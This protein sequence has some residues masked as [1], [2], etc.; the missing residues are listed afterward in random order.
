MGRFCASA[1]ARD[2]LL[3]PLSRCP[4]TQGARRSGLLA[5]KVIDG[6]YFTSTPLLVDNQP[7]SIVKLPAH[8]LPL[9]VAPEVIA[10]G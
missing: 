2:E 8:S 4:A 5:P 10:N 3:H 7:Y 9:A 1:V 6:E